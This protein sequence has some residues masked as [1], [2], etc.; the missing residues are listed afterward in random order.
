MA[1]APHIRLPRRGTPGSELLAR[2][3]SFR[4]H[5]ADWRAGKTWSLIYFGGE[6]LTEVIKQ[7]YLAFFSENALN[8]MAFPSLKRFES[9]VVAMTA[10]LLGGDEQ[11]VGNM[12]SGGSESLLMVVKTARDRARALRP[13]ITSPEIVLPASA[14]PALLKGAHY[15]GLTPVRV[16]VGPDL[17]ADV[18]SMGEAITDRTVLMVGSAPS[19]PHGVIDPIAGLAELARERGV[20]FHVDA[21]LGGFLLPFAARLG[22]PIPAFDFRL[23]G[24]TSI[25][26]DVHKYG[27]GAKG[28]SVILYRN[29]DIR[30]YQYFT[31][32]DWSGGLYASPTMTGTRPGGA[33]AAAWAAMNF[34]G[35]EGYLRL[36]ETTMRTA[37]ALMDGIAA[38]PGLRL[39][40][41]P[42]LSVFAF[43]SDEADVYVVAD[44]I[45]ARGWHLDRQ[46]L[47]PC[48][49]LM[50]TPA[51][52]AVVEPFLSDLREAVADAA[53][54]R[55]S[56]P[57]GMAPMYGAIAAMPE[58]SFVGEFLTSVLDEWTRS[59]PRLAEAEEEPA[60]PKA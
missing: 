16:P 59:E 44:A 15:F 1:D 37:R 42:D 34:L 7:A 45:E 17:R 58:R 18:R 23:P 10:G 39:L 12:T 38:I 24:V 30:R 14:H 57:G 35:E 52:A 31:C 2:M 56:V 5:D 11:V 3:Y 8:P 43:A 29:A 41:R 25:S 32:A 51:H 4:G 9:E 47:P 20:H 6:E 21:C 60:P 19:Y 28:A 49:H 13:E 27:Y 48:L 46:Q 40:G 33:I 50:V 53:A 54:G 26:A 22:Y 55:V 36:A